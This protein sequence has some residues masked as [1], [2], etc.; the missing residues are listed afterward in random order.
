[1]TREEKSTSV[2]DPLSR[3]IVYV[4]L[5]DIF[6]SSDEGGVALSADSACEVRMLEN[7]NGMF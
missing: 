6:V 1:V 3:S 7:G 5:G 4:D 2:G